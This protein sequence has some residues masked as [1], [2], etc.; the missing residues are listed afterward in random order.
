[1]TGTAKEYEASKKNFFKKHNNDFNTE[2][3]PMMNDTYHKEYMFRD[4]AI[5]YEVIRPVYEKV[6]VEVRKVKTQIDI[7][8]CEVEYWNTDNANSMTYCERW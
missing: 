4:G 3:S 8:L 6:E 7:K 1:M 2:T 5:W